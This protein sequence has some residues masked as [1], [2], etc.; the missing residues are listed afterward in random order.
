MTISVPEDKINR[1]FILAK[2][3]EYFEDSYA[4]RGML[5][6]IAKSLPSVTTHAEETEPFTLLAMTGPVDEDGGASLVPPDEPRERV[7]N[8]GTQSQQMWRENVAASKFMVN[9]MFMTRWL[10]S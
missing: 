3:L 6:S 1:G 8:I 7:L 2:H 5:D 10:L 9:G 4:W